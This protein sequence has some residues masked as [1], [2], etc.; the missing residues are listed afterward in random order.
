VNGGWWRQKA[1]DCLVPLYFAFLQLPRSFTTLSQ[2]NRGLKNRGQLDCVSARVGKRADC[3]GERLVVGS[4]LFRFGV[5]VRLGWDAQVT[6]VLPL[7]S[8]IYRDQFHSHFKFDSQL[9]YS[10]MSDQ[11]F[12]I[13]QPRHRLLQCRKEL[14]DCLR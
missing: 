9:C 14:P 1:S 12:R 8:L 4:S 2:R 7:V 11:H 10:Y 6:S 5:K 13:W 3:D